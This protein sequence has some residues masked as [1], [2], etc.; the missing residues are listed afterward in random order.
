MRLR[1]VA[2]VARELG[3]VV[4]DLCAVLG[5][6]VCFRDPGVAEF[7]L[8]NALMPIATSF[9]EV[10][11]PARAGTTAGRLLDKRG[12]DGGYMVI[13]QTD[14]LARE[15]RRMDE[16]GVRIVWQIALPDAETIHLHPRDVGGAIVSLDQMRPP[17]SWRWGG[18]DWQRHVRSDV[19]KAL[20]GAELQGPDPGALAARW[21]QVFGR[22]PTRA[23]DGTF[24]LALDQGL[25]RFV[26]ER[27]GRGEGVSGIDVAVVD[28]AEVVRR[29]RRRGARVD[30]DA[31]V[32]CG[33]RI[34]LLG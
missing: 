10:V 26:P 28:P 8:R 23:H 27:D 11:S 13:V 1:Q 3:P 31:V 9:L 20:I 4:E 18:P 14:D 22:M 24:A 34:R 6:E 2:L 7:G 16:L 15:R 21:G 32:L 30:G 19:T 25:L 33:T 5:L 17:E 12:G 29:A